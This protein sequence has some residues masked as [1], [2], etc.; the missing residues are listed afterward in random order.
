MEPLTTDE[1]R[2]VRLVARKEGL[3]TE[4]ISKRLHLKA[5]PVAAVAKG[6]VP[7]SAD[8]ISSLRSRGVLEG[9]AEPN[10]I[11]R[12]SPQVMADN[13]FYSAFQRVR[14]IVGVVMLLLPMWLV[15][16]NLVVGD[17]IKES[18]SSFYYSPMRDWFVGMLFAIAGALLAYKDCP[19]D[20]VWTRLACVAAVCVAIFPTTE[21]GSHT[22]IS[23]I[24]LVS[25]FSLFGLLAVTCFVSFVKPDPAKG[26]ASAYLSPVEKVAKDRRNRW[27]KR[28]AVLI[29]LCAVLLVVFSLLNVS[30]FTLE[31]AGLIIIGVAWIAKSNWLIEHTDLFKAFR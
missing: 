15:V 7:P 28:Y 19:G 21:D 14:I 9:G 24:H 11:L 26:G 8:P 4:A 5:A 6:P 27:Y 3:T 12:V 20:D 23:W 30:T 25:A 1:R 29:A 13:D 22:P 18:I 31:F 10:V 2:V 16:G 17:G